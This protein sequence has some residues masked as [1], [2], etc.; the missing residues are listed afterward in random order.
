MDKPTTPKLEGF[1]VTDPK[2]ED[3]EAPIYLSEIIYALKAV[4]HVLNTSGEFQTL[5]ME[6]E[7]LVTLSGLHSAANILA[8][9]IAGRMTG[10]DVVKKPAPRTRKPRSKPAGNVVP[11]KSA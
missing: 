7:S 6:H 11:L 8:N 3:H 2:A 5:N 4:T 9:L 10:E 1:Y